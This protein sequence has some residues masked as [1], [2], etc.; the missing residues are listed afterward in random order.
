MT[1]HIATEPTPCPGN[2]CKIV[3]ASGSPRRHQFLRD[4]GLAFDVVLSDIDETPYYGESPSDLVARLAQSKS[5][6]VVRHL[7]AAQRHLVIA[8]D[9]IVA[10]DGELLGKPADKEIARVM[11]RRLRNRVHQV[12]SAVTLLAVDEN[13]SVQQERTI[14]NSTDVYM[15]NYSEQELEA[16]VASGDPL[17]KAGAYA[18]Q[19]TDFAPGEKLDGCLS[20]VMGLPLADLCNCLANF[21]VKVEVDF[22]DLCE[23]HARFACCQRSTSE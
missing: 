22:R 16:Y 17:D 12:M 15:R 13:T 11:L 14:L 5:Y 6:A 18:I 2:G 20:G 21:G 9:T 4:L 19:H 8:A 23:R 1:V 3:L 10:V 7:P